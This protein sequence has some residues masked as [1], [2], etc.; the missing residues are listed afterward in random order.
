MKIAGETAE[1]GSKGRKSRPNEK[2]AESGGG[3]L[4]RG[5]NAPSPP[6]RGL[7][8]Q[9]APPGEAPTTQRFSTILSTRDGLS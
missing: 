9:W 7:G 5:Q 6:A 8:A 2:K 1:W 3:F 4:G